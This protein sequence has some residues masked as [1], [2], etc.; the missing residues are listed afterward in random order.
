MKFALAGASGFLG[1]ALR[2]RLAEEGHDVVRLVRREPAT[3][4]ERRWD[5]DAHQVDPSV[6]DGVDVVVNLAGAGVADR[7]WSEA[8]RKLI[9]SSRVNTTSTLAVALAG[10]AGQGEDIAT[11]VL[12]NASGISRYG[13][14]WSDTAADEETPAGSDYLSQVVVKW[15]G[16]AQPAVD[17][18]VR[19]VFLRTSPVMD[20][21]GGPLGLM[22][23]PWSLGLGAQLGDGSQ[24][25]P[26]IGLH[27][28][29]RV[30][31]WT[32]A[33]NSANGAYNLTIPQPAT[34]AEFTKA[35]ARVLGRPSFLRAPAVVMRTALGELSEQLLGDMYVL[36]RRLIAE[37]FVFDGTDVTSTLKLAFGR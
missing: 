15:E 4:T 1:S 6:F 19:V 37:G 22:K 8:R 30:L 36:P 33:N 9:L 2:V 18:G 23:F 10:L 24:R 12:I 26:L 32:A 35:L 7:P 20:P 31:L 5:P 34:N 29:L 3:A 16:A 17:A 21:S 25:M 14:Q 13:T 27:D 28:Y 11:P